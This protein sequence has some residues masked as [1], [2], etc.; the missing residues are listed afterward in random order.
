LPPSESRHFFICAKTSRTLAVFTSDA[1]SPSAHLLAVR[2]CEDY[3][4]PQQSPAPDLHAPGTGH[5]DRCCSTPTTHL[6]GG[7]RCACNQRPHQPRARDLLATRTAHV[8]Q[9]QSIPSGHLL[10]GHMCESHMRQRLPL[11]QDQ[12]LLA[13][14]SFIFA[15][16]HPS[17]T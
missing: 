16:T 11:A 5:K 3:Q 8:H 14:A 12:L 17:A 7:R 1:R 4:L 15:K 13:F 9:R 6:L 2:R 10:A